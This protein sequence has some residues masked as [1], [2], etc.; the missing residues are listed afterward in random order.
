M[1]DTQFPHRDKA[2]LE[3]LYATG[4]CC[5]ELVKIQLKD[6]DPLEQTIK[7]VGK[8]KKERLVTFRF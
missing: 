7:I 4:I 6:I 5:S 1:Q 3:M 2:I 8:R